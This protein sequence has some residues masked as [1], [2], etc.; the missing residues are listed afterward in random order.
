M[1][2]EAENK[3][4]SRRSLVIG[5]MLIAIVVLMTLVILGYSKYM[6]EEQSLKTDRGQ[7]LAE[8]YVYAQLFADRLRDG[9][10]GFLVAKTE[11][12]KVRAAKEIAEARLA[13]AEAL[14]LFIEAESSASGQSRTEVSEAIMLAANAVI[15]GESPLAAIG[16]SG[17]PLTDAEISFL[18]NV[19]DGA[20]VIADALNKF[21]SP[22]GEVGYR[23]MVSMGEWKPHALEASAKLRELASA[24]NGQN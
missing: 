22:S 11:A 2:A 14:G 17:A 10:E 8:R 15:G 9:S 13:G 6:L 12:E 1:P 23:Q 20:A 24:L 5:A 7:R 4:K 3:I 19:R 18:T 16:E 21:R